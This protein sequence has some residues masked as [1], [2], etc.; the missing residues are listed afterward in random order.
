MASQLISNYRCKLPSSTYVLKRGKIKYVYVY[1]KYHP[2]LNNTNNVREIFIGKL[3]EKHNLLI[4]NEN[5]LNYFNKKEEDLIDI[6]F[7]ISINPEIDIK[8]NISVG[9]DIMVDYLIKKTSLLDCL[10][11]SFGSN[12]TSK[13]INIAKY[14]VCERSDVLYDFDVYASKH[15]DVNFSSIDCSSIFAQVETIDKSKFYKLWFDKCTNN[16]SHTIA[17][18]V[19]SVSSYSTSYSEIEKGYNRD[20]EKLPQ[21]NIGLMCDVNNGYPIFID[22]YCGSLTD[23]DNLI[24]YINKAKAIGIDGFILVMD[25][26]FFEEDKIIYLNSKGY[27]FYVGMPSSLKISK[28]IIDNTKDITDFNNLSTYYGVYVKENS[29]ENVLGID[30]KTIIIY[31]TNN[32]E[33]CNVS[34]LETINKLKQD[35]S[36]KTI[37]KYSTIIKQNKYTSY[38]DI[39]PLDDDLSYTYKFNEEKA[40]ELN[41][42]NGYSCVFTNIKEADRFEVLNAYRMKDEDEKLFYEFKNSLNGYRLHTHGKQTTEGKVFV[43]FI[44]LCIRRIIRNYSKQ[45]RET[46]KEM[47]LKRYIEK[48]KDLEIININ[49]TYYKNHNVNKAYREMFE[50]CGIDLNIELDNL[51]ERKSKK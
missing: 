40:K 51:I 47:T 50:E 19:T 14:M 33:L 36:N 26:G 3:D 23:P 15:F 48:L 29:D 10:K 31:D 21:I 13:I 38:F 1:T 22:S 49:D 43:M 30:G 32:R 20:L 2:E 35:L 42:R 6:G 37:K 9:F 34:S 16:S 46:H 5:Y 27:K 41:K 45:Y 25:G 44:A 18:D 28:N 24:A 7:E 11:A 39:N 4:P 8:P 17:Y 12:L